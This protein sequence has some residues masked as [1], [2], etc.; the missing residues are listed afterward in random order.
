MDARPSLL[1][2]WGAGAWH[3]IPS[4]LAEFLESTV[5]I[6]VGSRDD[7]LFPESV[8]AMGARVEPG[9][10]ELTVFLPEAT[11]A[12]TLANLRSNGRIA[13]CFSRPADHQS[14]QLKGSVREIAPAP[15]S[16]RERIER[17]RAGLAKA[18]GEYGMPPRISY[19]VAYWPSQAVR[20][21]IESMF[22]QTPGPG[23]GDPLPGSS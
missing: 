13:V 2:E 23:A 14:V 20:V 7:F 21:E 9:G 1:L 15:D 4:D 11:N 3:L 5:S 18:L 12:S 19:R 8:R 17:Y 22:V 6:L 16:D 10:K